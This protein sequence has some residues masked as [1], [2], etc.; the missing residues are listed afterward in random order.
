MKPYSLLLCSVLAG[1]VSIDIELAVPNSSVQPRLVGEDCVG[2]Y[3]GIG[4]GT[5]RAKDAL[6]SHAPR[7]YGAPVVANGPMIHRI[8]SITLKDD[9]GFGFGQRCIEVK[10]E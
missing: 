2:I 5:A 4:F 1:C 8:H 3:F 10:G 7:A 9:M 6:R